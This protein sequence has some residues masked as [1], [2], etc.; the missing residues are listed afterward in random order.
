MLRLVGDDKSL[1]EPSLV[2]ISQHLRQAADHL[3]TAHQMACDIE[4]VEAAALQEAVL[5]AGEK[6]AA[7]LA[8]MIKEISYREL[9]SSGCASVDNF[10]RRS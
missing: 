7:V 5:Q 4:L 10:E 8:V 9:S 6:I 3:S 1:P 2:A